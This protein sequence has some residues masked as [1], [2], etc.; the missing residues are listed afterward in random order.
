MQ[1]GRGRKLEIMGRVG[2]GVKF[3]GTILALILNQCMHLTP[4]PPPSRNSKFVLKVFPNLM[5]SHEKLLGN[6]N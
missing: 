4:P 2:M 1:E 5:M 3:L 6:P